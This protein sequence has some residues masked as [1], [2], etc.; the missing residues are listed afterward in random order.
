MT[1]KELRQKKAAYYK[2]KYQLIKWNDY[3]Y[4]KLKEIMYIRR[5]G[6]ADNDTYSDCII[7][8][9]TEY[10]QECW[11]FLKWWTSAD[12]QLSYNNNVE[13]IL[14]TVSRTTTATLEAFESMAWE[15]NDLVVLLEQRRRIQEIP[16]VPGSYYV[17]RS[18]D[19]AFWGVVNDVDTPKDSLM[20]WN[21]ISNS[22]IE[23]KIK[24]YI[25]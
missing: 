23:R 15:K 16:E 25:K 12:T 6:R 9:D 13:S 21:E 4:R 20:K 11:E 24:Q 10:P 1:V 3:K 5:A 17:S 18:V 19:Q 8:A 7:M 22:E 14:G 2:G